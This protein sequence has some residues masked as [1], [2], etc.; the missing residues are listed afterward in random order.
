MVKTDERETPS[1]SVEELRAAIERAK[2]QGVIPAGSDLEKV[3]NQKATLVHPLLR[4]PKP[5]KKTDKK[6]RRTTVR[7]V[8]LVA[9][10]TDEFGREVPRLMSLPIEPSFNNM[11]SLKDPSNPLRY[12]LNKGYIFPH[13]YEGTLTISDPDTG[14]ER[15]VDLQQIFC[16]VKDCW[17]PA[18]ATKDPNG[19]ELCAY[20]KER[21]DKGLISWAISAREYS[22]G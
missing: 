2:D 9:I 16:A 20:D 12:W 5:Q 1:L 21:W 14:K 3:V 19:S 4:K 11:G 10:G 22:G 8:K 15:E 18:L 13:D 6:Q 7:S 17:E